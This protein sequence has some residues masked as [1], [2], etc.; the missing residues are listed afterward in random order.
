ME[1][2]PTYLSKQKKTLNLHFLLKPQSKV[3]I[4]FSIVIQ[5]KSCLYGIF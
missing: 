4:L 3:K 5:T 2:V 1:Y